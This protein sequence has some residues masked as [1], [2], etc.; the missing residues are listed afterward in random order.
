[1]AE[2]LSPKPE[3]VY[4]GKIFEIEH[5]TQPDG[6]IFERA[7]RAPGVRVIIADQ[8]RRKVLLTKEYRHELQA[9]DY[10]LP[11]GKVFDTLEEYDAF[12]ASG[13]DIME[14]ATA[15]AIAESG[16]EAGIHIKSIQYLKTSTLGAT[17]GWDLLF[18]EATDWQQAAE[19][20]RLEA[21]ERIETDNWLEYDEARQMIMQGQMQEER[22]ALVLLQWLETQ[23]G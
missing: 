23:H 10:R 2:S 21:G 22:V 8:E 17:V 4:R 12:R 13:G 7:V 6:R 3:I 11:G 20:Q 16:E 14:P 5:T 19:G 1:M 15:K 18:F 9:W